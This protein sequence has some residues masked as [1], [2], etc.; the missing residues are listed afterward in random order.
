MWLMP[1]HAAVWGVGPAIA[2]VLAAL[3]T[4]AASRC[5]PLL[6]LLLLLLLTA[7]AWPHH[8]CTC[9]CSSRCPMVAWTAH[10]G[11]AMLLS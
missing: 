1:M 4:M 9:T 3:G 6:L 7:A 10:C 11:N 5:R 8:V 2:A